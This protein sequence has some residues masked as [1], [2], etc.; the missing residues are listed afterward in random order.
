[1][2]STLWRRIIKETQTAEARDA[3]AMV[4]QRVPK[5]T[6]QRFVETY[7]SFVHETPSFHVPWYKA[8]DDPDDDKLL[9][10]AP[11]EHAK[12]STVLGYATK[13]ICENRDLRIGIMSQ[14][15]PLAIGFMRTIKRNLR[16]NRK[17]I[18]VY[19][20]FY[21]DEKWSNQEI[22][23]QG[24]SRSGW[25][26]AD[27][28][29]F[30]MG[31]GSQ[32]TGRHCD[33]L[34]F[35]DVESLQTVKTSGRRLNTKAWFSREVTP[36]LSPGGKQI[37][38]G[39]RKHF[40]DLY[41]SLL[42][43]KSGW[44]VLDNALAA[45]LPNGKPLWPDQWSIRG[46]LERKASLD[47]TDIR[48]WPQEYENRPIAGD[49]QMFEPD[50]WPKYGRLPERLKLYQGWDLAISER[51]SSDYT[52]CVTIGVD[53]YKNVYLLSVVRGHWTI[54][55]VKVEM[56][57]QFR[58]WSNMGWGQ[59]EAVAIEEAGFQAPIIRDIIASVHI[60][61]RGIKPPGDKIVHARYLE[62][63][64]AV[65]SVYA[66]EEATEWWGD[67]A[68]EALEFPAGAHDDQIDGF[69][70]A[71]DIALP[72]SGWE[73]HFD[74]ELNA[75]ADV[76]P[77][78]VYSA[79]TGKP[80][81]VVPDD[82]GKDF[83]QLDEEHQQKRKEYVAVLK[84]RLPTNGCSLCRGPLDV[85]RTFESTEVDGIF[86]SEQCRIFAGRIP[87]FKKAVA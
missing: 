82:L 76:E 83:D 7:L 22:I 42:L 2:P 59:V 17:L 87:R 29:I 43:P 62:A 58:V 67:F 11:R 66:P 81:P 10:L 8:Y 4:S 44:H 35:D 6:T 39:S 28:S 24:A 50:K 86:C 14:S 13:R 40:D 68:R 18:D 26:A 61:A 31:A 70:Y 36:V 23:V 55:R 60:P 74:K 54:K 56:E 63:R 80:I 27:V 30:A 32:V 78:M 49:Q 64:A 12:S 57:R 37:V 52:V 33:V 9:L 48:A 72:I 73:H 77:E 51:T 41:G 79:L 85:R 16:F 5:T 1:M 47:A 53:E 69:G 45:I 65:S 21:S 25:G 3:V 75:L 20:E 84:E 46:L 34:I 19:G 71:L 38:I 15:S